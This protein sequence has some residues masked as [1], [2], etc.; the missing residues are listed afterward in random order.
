MPAEK[1][2]EEEESE[3]KPEDEDD[4]AEALELPMNI[5]ELVHQ[6][7]QQDNQLNHC[8]RRTTREGL[9]LMIWCQLSQPTYQKMM[10]SHLLL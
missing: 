8:S 10:M 9:I 4:L 5:A 6:Q 3:A 7:V 1:E 2:E